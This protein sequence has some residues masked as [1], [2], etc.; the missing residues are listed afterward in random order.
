MESSRTDIS[1]ITVVKDDNQGLKKTLKS[2]ERALN[3]RI[4][5]IIIDGSTN[6]DILS[7]VG[8]FNSELNIRITFLEPAGIYHAMN[9]GARNANGEWLWFLNAGDYCVLSRDKFEEIQDSLSTYDHEIVGIVS[10][11][12]IA[13]H[14]GHIYDIAL[15]R[16]FDEEVHC[17]HQGVFVKRKAYEEIGGF[18]ETLKLAADGKFLDSLLQFGKIKE[19][20]TVITTFVMGGRSARNFRT[21]LEEIATYRSKK[22]SDKMNSLLMIK[23]KLRNRMLTESILRSSL[24][25]MYLMRRENHIRTIFNEIVELPLTSSMFR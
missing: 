23:T 1:I 12:V 10:P 9:A 17:N 5:V 7:V 3:S 19:I 16:I 18:D 2:L 20:N 6:S 8:D 11:V 22:A 25:Q 14:D 15:P 24:V 21:T 4:E 13:T